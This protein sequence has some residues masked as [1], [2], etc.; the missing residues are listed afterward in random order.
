[1]IDDTFRVIDIS[2]P[3][4]AARNLEDAKQIHE[5]EDFDR[6]PIKDN[7]GNIKEYCD[8]NE[9]KLIEIKSDDLIPESCR[10]I[11]TFNYLSKKS[12]YFI[13]TENKITHIV[14]YSDLNNML[15][16]IRLYTQIAYCE[17]A[18]RDYAKSNNKYGN[19]ERGIENFLKDINNN[20]KSV[21]KIDIKQAKK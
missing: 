11:E 4:I 2:N 3:I 7:N 19:T 12:F 1:M 20:V 6:V 18:I 9:D 15:V 14:H 17:I 13:S 8:S 21:N 16:L 5:T 10:L